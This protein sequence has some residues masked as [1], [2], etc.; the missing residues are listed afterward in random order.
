MADATPLGR[1]K[2]HVEL[3]G[4]GV[5]RVIVDGHDISRFVSEVKFDAAVGDATTV[6]LTLLAADVRAT[7]DQADTVILDSLL[8]DHVPLALVDD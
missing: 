4:L 2:V 1:R 6:R 5:G 7:L 8:E 3:N